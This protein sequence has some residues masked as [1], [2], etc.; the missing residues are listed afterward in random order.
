MDF[1]LKDL[2][3]PFGATIKRKSI[4]IES[5]IMLNN[6]VTCTHLPDKFVDMVVNAYLK[7]V[8]SRFR[9]SRKTVEANLEIHCCQK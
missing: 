9:G 3:G 6:Y 4:C 5:D 7:E 8:Y 2:F 1:I